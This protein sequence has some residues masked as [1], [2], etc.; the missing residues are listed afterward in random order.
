MKRVRNVSKHIQVCERKSFETQ[1][2]SKPSFLQPWS[3]T[4]QPY[5]NFVTWWTVLQILCQNYAL[6]LDVNFLLF[7]CLFFNMLCYLNWLC[8]LVW[9]RD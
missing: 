2:S 8:K 5:L 3:S 4:L 9:K 7:A 6:C 1:L